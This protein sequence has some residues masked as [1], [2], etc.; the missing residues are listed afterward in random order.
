MRV[1]LSSVRV[2]PIGVLAAN[3]LLLA[4]ASAHHAFW[5]DEAQAWLLARDSASLSALL[6]NLRYEGHPPLWHLVLFPLAHLSGNPQWM[7]LPHILCALATNALLLFAKPLP[8]IVRVLAPF[9]YFL[10]FEYGVIVRNY[11][12]GILLLRAAP[13]RR[14]HGTAPH[15]AGPPLLALAALSSLPAAI[16]AS[17]LFAVYLHRSVW[18][19]PAAKDAPRFTAVALGSA[20][21]A[22]CLAVSISFIVPAADSG[23]LLETQPLSA[24]S[25]LLI[26]TRLLTE[27]YLPIPLGAPL[28]WNHTVAEAVPPAYSILVGGLLF[29]AMLRVGLRHRE[30]RVFFAASS[31]LLL[32][33]MLLTQRAFLRHTGWL[34]I[35]L[36]AALLLD[37]N[38]D[39]R[40]APTIPECDTRHPTAR[41]RRAH[42]CLMLALFGASACS[43]LF[44]LM[45][46]LNRPFSV[47]PEAEALLRSEQLADA[48]LVF[49]PDFLGSAILADLGRSSAWSLELGQPQSFAVWNRA[50][51]RNRH[52]PTPAEWAA[53]T[54]RLGPAPVLITASPVPESLLGEL[55]LQS[56][57]SFGRAMSG[58][59]FFLYHSRPEH[60]PYPPSRESS[61]GST[62]INSSRINSRSDMDGAT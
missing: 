6:K 44:V 39:Q 60:L 45:V 46:S 32:A 47:A 55:R 58:D 43:G 11:A 59:S 51:Y 13:L 21:F 1:Q 53:L 4:L 25:C 26:G 28:F 12:P 50:E 35:V 49:E 20:L 61:E 62:R 41:L 2:S 22:A 37:G 42:L 3:M 30:A 54:A 8:M 34:F 7:K 5:R 18:A 15:G 17:C 10:L 56:I 23:A 52:L 40:P 27:A 24:L 38:G 31:V 19:L 48:P 16:V 9:S 36:L 29:L 57:G 14:A 33:Q